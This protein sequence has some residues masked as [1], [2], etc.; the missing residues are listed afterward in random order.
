MHDPL[1]EDLLSQQL[2][3]LFWVENRATASGKTTFQKHIA[4]TFHHFLLLFL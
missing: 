1:V 3:K 4:R 2:T